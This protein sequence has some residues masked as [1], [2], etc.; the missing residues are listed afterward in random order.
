MAIAPPSLSNGEWKVTYTPCLPTHYRVTVDGLVHS[1]GEG[2][3]L[4]AAGGEGIGISTESK[5]LYDIVGAQSIELV[6]TAH[7]QA[8]NPERLGEGLTIVATS[9]DGVVEAIEHQDSL[10]ALALQWHPER[11][12][13]CDSRGVDVDQDLCNAL[14]GAL[15]HYAGEHAA[16]AE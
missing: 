3:H 14:L 8:V 5:W 2:Y 9:S 13:L 1:G 4:L 15:V 11:D 6:A 7:H 12:A 10:F 16:L